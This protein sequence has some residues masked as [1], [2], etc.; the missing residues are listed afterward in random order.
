MASWVEY[1]PT[2][3]FPLQNLPYGVFHT[4]ANTT[5]RCCTTI[6]DYVVDL[7]V[8]S[9]R[10]LLPKEAG[11]SLESTTLNA[12]MALGRP[13]WSA[14]RSALTKL[15]SAS[16]AKLRDDSALRAA[17]MLPRKEAIMELPASIG[18]YTDFYS[19]KEHA[20]N[21][22]RMFRPGQPA[23]LPNW[24]WLPVAYHGRAS[25]IKVSG[26]PIRRPWGQ[27]R[28]NPEENPI[29]GPSKRIDMEIEV[30]AWVGS[31]NPLGEPVKIK[32]TKDHVFGLSVFNDWSARD[33]Q[34]WE[35]VPL[36]PFLAKNFAS[37][38]SPW[39][40]TLDALEPFMTE[41]PAQD[42]AP[43]E[44]LK[45]PFPKTAYDIKLTA[46]LTLGDTKESKLI[47]Q[48]NYKYMYWS[49]FQQYAH[50]TV[51]GCNLQPGDVF[52]SGTIS[53]STLGSWGSLIEI[54]NRGENPIEFPSGA[55]RC[56]LNDGDSMTL[57]AM[58]EGDG[59]CIGFGE[60]EATVVPAH[61]SV[62]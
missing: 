58:C 7:S 36:G 28:P 34:P 59:Y 39:I 52:A 42:P 19:S 13:A 4:S 25:S 47:S 5:P 33:V 61:E 45:N 6:G 11:A 62:V 46:T 49:L 24:T 18:D 12:F 8:L 26:T 2:H 21:L 51:N 9:K 23:L 15:F 1:L 29:F 30:A 44:Y 56:F 38:I 50:H 20:T 60:A 57:S 48:T 27:S 53:G 14:V 37:T 35:Y 10:G 43:M 22:G 32:D 41:G 55:K 3:P 40:V 17:C 16:E 54:T 31:P